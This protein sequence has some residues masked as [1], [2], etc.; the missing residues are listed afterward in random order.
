MKKE[1][2]AAHVKEPENKRRSS[3]HVKQA[4]PKKRREKPRQEA[5]AEPIAKKSREPKVKKPRDK[6]KLVIT[7]SIVAAVLL[8]TVGGGL[9]AGCRIS[10]SPLILPN[11]CVGSIDLGGLDAQQARAELEKSWQTRAE[12]PLTVSSIGGAKCS[13]DP[14]KSGMTLSVDS[15]VEAAYAHGHD[16]NIVQNLFTYIKRVFEPVDVNALSAAANSDYLDACIADLISAV[17]EYMGMEE[18][19]I[20]FETARLSMKKG[21]DQIAFNVDDMRQSMLSA[22]SEGKTELEYTQLS[23]ELK[24]PD[25]KAIY[26]EYDKEPRDASYSEDGKFEVVDEVIGCR[27]DVEEAKRAW[28]EA[29][30]G[31][32][33]SIP[34]ELV[35]PQVTGAELRDRLFH[36]LLGACTTKYPNSGEQ[37]RSN[38][39]LATSILNEYILYPGETISFNETVGERTEE[40]GFLPAPAYVDG[41]VK[42]EIG[43]GVCQVSSTLYA[44]TAFAFLETVERECHFFPVNYMQLGTDATVTIPEGGRSVDFKFKNNKNYPIKIVG[45]CDNE[46][47]TITFEIWG[48][49]EEN[50]YMPIKFDNSY[51][52]EFDYMRDVEPSYEGRAGYTIKL[53]HELYS[54]ED[55]YGPGYRT[56][57]YREVYDENGQRVANQIL[58]PQRGN[59]NYAMDTYYKH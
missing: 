23:K 29:M 13:V 31:E 43:G 44:A 34:L 35:L 41:D 28:D 45:Y 12:T 57:T 48:T 32:L 22:L 38:L 42:D 8:L 58:N 6:R 17:D 5:A 18:Y 10:E 46:N 36:D 30:P 39:R 49:L 24:A 11:V 21:W 56:L 55:D 33:I 7:L 14:V 59:G 51:G 40:A 27:F 16:G 52:W 3:S 9:Y 1:V 4:E 37:R 47:S 20:D 26:K 15:A 25:F 19:T 50:D 54:F 53:V 2:R